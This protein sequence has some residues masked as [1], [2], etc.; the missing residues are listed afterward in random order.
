M[1]INPSANG[2]IIELYGSNP[3][4]NEK[5]F[6][7]PA[8]K[9][10]KDSITFFTYRAFLRSNEKSYPAKLKNSSWYSVVVS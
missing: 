6:M 5:K 3:E 4:T 8:I 1:N 10:F 7:A 2:S 9:I